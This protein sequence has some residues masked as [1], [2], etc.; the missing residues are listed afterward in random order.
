M[1]DRFNTRRAAAHGSDA[2][3]APNYCIGIFVVMIGVI[4]PFT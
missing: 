1:I 3:S 2:V 4:T